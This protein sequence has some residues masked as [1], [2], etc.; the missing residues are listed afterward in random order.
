MHDV[1][2]DYSGNGYTRYSEERGQY[3]DLCKLRALAVLH[4]KGIR[5][6]VNPD[7]FGVDIL[8]L[9]EQDNVVEGIELEIHPT[10]TFWNGPWPTQRWP[11]IHVFDRKRHMTLPGH[12]PTTFWIINHDA[13]WIM[14]VKGKVIQ[15]NFNRPHNKYAKDK[16]YVWENMKNRTGNEDDVMRIPVKFGDLEFIGDQGVDWLKDATKEDLRVARTIPTLALRWLPRK[17]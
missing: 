17:H 1:Q 7:Q 13:T 10:D 16:V 5:A 8:I 11:M 4:E 6:I 14:K 2:F 12:V 9:D 3:D 15:E